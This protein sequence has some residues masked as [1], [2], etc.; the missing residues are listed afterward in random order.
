[1][2]VGVAAGPSSV[3]TSVAEGLISDATS[4]AGQPTGPTAGGQEQAVQIPG[5]VEPHHSQAASEPAESS[6]SQGGMA[7]TSNG[8]KSSGP[9]TPEVRRVQN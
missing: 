3:R 7:A 8:E 5:T 2:E 6:D 4:P 9:H 1:M